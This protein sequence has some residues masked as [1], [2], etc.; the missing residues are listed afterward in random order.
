MTTFRSFNSLSDLLLLTIKLF[1]IMV[2][3]VSFTI[4]AACTLMLVINVPWIL[5]FIFLLDLITV[6]MVILCLFEKMEPHRHQGCPKIISKPME[7]L[8]EH[9]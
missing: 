1:F 6:F 3:M 4:L 9:M 5:K 7:L 8:D 2:I